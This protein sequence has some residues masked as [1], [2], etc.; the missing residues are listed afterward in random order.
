MNCVVRVDS[1]NRMGVGHVTRCVTLALALRDRGA[2]VEFVCRDH[3]GHFGR[4]LHDHALPVTLLPAP[5]PSDVPVTVEDYGA[6]LGVPPA[7][8]A[9]QTVSALRGTRPD[10]L[11]VD[12][13]SLGLEWERHLRPHVG[14][15]LVIDD[16]PSRRH[17]CDLLLNQNFS[18]ETAERRSALV[19]SG[20]RVLLGPHYALLRSEYSSYRR[21]APSRPAEIRRMLVYFGGADP[22]NMTGLA[23]EA[24]SQPACSTLEVDVVIGV[25]H[26]HRRELEL[27]AARRPLTRV[28]GSRPHLAD[29]IAAAD[30]AIGAGG[31]MTWERM[32]LGLPSIVINC[33]DN[34][35]PACEA[36][37]Q[38]GLI[39]YLGMHSNVRAA[40]V[41]AAV[42][43]WL[44]D[45]SQPAAVAARGRQEVDGLGAWRMAELLVPTSADA[46]T[47]RA[48]DHSTASRALVM[49][50]GNLPVGRIEAEHSGEDET[51]LRCAVDPCVEPRGW[52]PRFVMALNRVLRSSQPVPVLAA[53]DRATGAT[54]AR[55]LR[56][57]DGP[58]P[59]PTGPPAAT[60]RIAI[61]SDADSWLNP[62][63]AEMVWRWLN[64][65]HRVLWAHRERELR[66]A[67]FCF[68]LGCGQIVSPA[69]LSSYRHNL[70]VHESDLPQGKGWSPLTWQILEGRDTIV[71][72][73]FEAA[74][75]VDS[76][77]IYAQERMDFTGDELIDDLRAAQSNATRSL[78]DRFVRGFPGILAAARA[79]SGEESFYPRRR[80]SD[81]RVQ[82]DRTL[83]ELFDQLRVADPDRYPAFFDRNGA[84]Y[85]VRLK[86]AGRSD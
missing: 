44:S 62:M 56:L 38:A 6:W 16:L 32:C 4:L 57:A 77:V 46:L 58:D 69:T 75:R 14:R 47:W 50:A 31:A 39:R 86:K 82:Q 9:E 85:E 73:L 84:R 24:L 72:T 70:V 63:L 80:P 13:Y 12:H 20:A 25:N 48:D 11:I 42:A 65:G 34:Q 29:L 36:L 1:S 22:Y 40:D 37:H 10:W 33:A 55:F 26:A 51:L 5:P 27:Q 17:E 67:D 2:H 43:E 54:R 76:G 79:Q 15:V 64:D 61:L 7:V 81:S 52:Q 71:V 53:S 3:P 30:A 21:T 59:G 8:D 66:P 78:C 68:Y 19:A 74:E 49:Q 18:T 45:P 60:Y 41:T 35:R 83:G 23:L 28:H